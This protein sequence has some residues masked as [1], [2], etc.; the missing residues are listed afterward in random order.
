[1]ERDGGLSWRGMGA[2]L[3]EE[4]MDKLIGR[5]LLATSSLGAN[6]EIP[7][8]SEMGGLSKKVTDTSCPPK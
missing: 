1:M 4:W 8:K 5:L 2:K 7:Q 3:L 6:L